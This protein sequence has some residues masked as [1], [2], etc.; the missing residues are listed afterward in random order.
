MTTLFALNRF[1]ANATNKKTHKK[2]TFW[3]KAPSHRAFQTGNAKQ[4]AGLIKELDTLF[5]E[6]NMQRIDIGRRTF[7]AT[8]VDALS[9]AVRTLRR[10]RRVPNDS[11]SIC[12]GQFD[13][14]QPRHPLH[15]IR[16]STHSSHSSKPRHRHSLRSRHASKQQAPS[17]SCHNATTQ[18]V[19]A[20]VNE[21]G[22]LGRNFT[23]DNPD[24]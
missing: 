8:I 4:D 1:T 24:I 3:C 12:S 14:D 22:Y 19:P 17:N 15:S 16:K 23:I 7:V 9:D 2:S 6:F 13:T 21:I 5:A 11:L 20:I 10:N 18:R